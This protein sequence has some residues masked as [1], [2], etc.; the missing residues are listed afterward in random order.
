MASVTIKNGK[1][2][3]KLTKREVKLLEDANALLLTI[4]SDF[5]NGFDDDIWETPGTVL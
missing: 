2:S 4:N 1:R 5:V 3:L